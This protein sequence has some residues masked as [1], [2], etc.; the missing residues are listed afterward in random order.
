MLLQSM[1]PFHLLVVGSPRF[2]PRAS[3]GERVAP[4]CSGT[5]G[6]GAAVRQESWA[7]PADA[8]IVAVFAPP[9]WER[10]V[11]V[12]PG[13][14]SG[15]ESTWT[16]AFYVGSGN[17]RAAARCGVGSPGGMSVTGGISPSTESHMSELRDVGT[18]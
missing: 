2:G 15:M 4:L 13:I 7:A 17:S 9:G 5:W 10:A 14:T 12:A 16:G 6:A 18:K 11:A 1:E 8:S 3:A